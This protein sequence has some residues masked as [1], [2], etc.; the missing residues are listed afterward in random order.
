MQ[1][2]VDAGNL[3][4]VPLAQALETWGKQVAVGKMNIV[5]SDG[6]EPRLVVDDSICNTNALCHVNESYSN[7]TLAS[8]RAAFP[9]R[10]DPRPLGAFA[11]KH[12]C[13]QVRSGSA[14][15]AGWRATLLLP[16]LSFWCHLFS[17]VVCSSG[18][19]LCSGTS[20]ADICATRAFLIR[21]QFLAATGFGSS[22]HHSLAL[23]HFLC[24]L[25]YTLELEKVAVGVHGR[26][27]W[28]GA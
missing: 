12:P 13:S 9:L 20:S 16:S 26:V 8:V 25:W 2:E 19:I 24:V 27:D 6:R 21:G 22:G 14:G 23:H 4:E 28:L 7:P 3:V 15:G 17:A 10:G 18:I 11:M 5:H 1:S